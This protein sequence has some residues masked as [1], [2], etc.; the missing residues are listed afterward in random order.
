MSET[1]RPDSKPPESTVFCRRTQRDLPVHEHQDCP[2]C[3]RAEDVDTGVHGKFC[4]FDPEK[5]PVS[6]GFPDETTR[7]Q[8][9]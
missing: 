8:S 6:F 7:R 2:Y 9:G 4:N 5:D 1:D 3:H